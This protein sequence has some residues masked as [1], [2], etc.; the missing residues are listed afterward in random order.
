MSPVSAWA[1]K[2]IIETRPWPRTFA[3]PLA[4]GKAIEWSPPRTTGMAPARVTRSTAASSLGSDALD[5]AGVHLDVAGVD[6]PEV[7]EAVGA[8]RQRRARAVVRQVVGHPDRLRTEPGAGPVRGAAVERCAEDHDV[9]V[10]IRALVVEVAAVHAEE[11]E[12]RAVLLP[13]ARHGSNLVPLRAMG[14]SG[15][16][17]PTASRSPPAWAPPA[18]RGT[19]TASKASGPSTPLPAPGAVGEQLEGDDGVDGGLPDDAL[20]AV[21]AHRLLVVGHVEEVGAAAAGRPCRCR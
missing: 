5:V 12:V 16:P 21:L 1:S 19:G 3:T 14:I 10:G 2:W 17:C 20:G 13:V 9:G 7:D 18:G 15:L 6:D 8:Q 4:S 11:G